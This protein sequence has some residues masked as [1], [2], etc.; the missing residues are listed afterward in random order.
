MD[1][2]PSYWHHDRNKA[3]FLKH[4]DVIMK[5]FA[6]KWNKDEMKKDYLETFSTDN[7][8]KMSSSSQMLHSFPRCVA[9]AEQHSELQQV[10]PL[11]P[12]FEPPLIVSVNLCG[13]LSQADDT[14][15]ALKELNQSFTSV[16]NHDFTSSL[17]KTCE[18][19]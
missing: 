6:K 18:A 14:H 12:I 3:L 2:P 17:I 16:Y 4:C 10:F 7:W 19:T 15:G 11:L 5:C 8:N 1:Q 13:G 9:C